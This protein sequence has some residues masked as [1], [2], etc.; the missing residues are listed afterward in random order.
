M[1]NSDDCDDTDR[2]ITQALKLFRDKDGDR[3][4]DPDDSKDACTA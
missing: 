3:L 4:G 1:S 2:G